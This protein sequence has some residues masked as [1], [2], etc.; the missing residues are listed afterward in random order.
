MF[1]VKFSKSSG[2][3]LASN[4]SFVARMD[5]LSDKFSSVSVSSY[6]PTPKVSDMR[7][8]L[9]L[10]INQHFSLLSLFNFFNSNEKLNPVFRKR[11]SQRRFDQTFGIF[12]ISTLAP[13]VCA[14]AIVMREEQ[15]VNK[16]AKYFLVAFGSGIERVLNFWA[17]S[18]TK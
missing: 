10:A 17:L 3:S 11:S 13:A 12:G 18:L 16:G 9:P 6:G 4:I 2:L 8:W 5:I 14:I 7:P 1:F 15:N